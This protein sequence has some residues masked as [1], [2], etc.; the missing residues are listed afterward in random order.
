M[1]TP[2]ERRQLQLVE[3]WFDLNDPQL[4]RALRDGP[5]RRASAMPQTIAIVVMVALAGLGIL[6]GAFPL[7]LGAILAGLVA[8]G[9][10]V[11][12]KKSEA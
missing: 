11:H 1:F 9:L 2:Y 3:E 5:V 4:A 10:N 12:R 6:T 8:G 7:I